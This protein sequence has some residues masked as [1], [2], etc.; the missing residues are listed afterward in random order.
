MKKNILILFISFLSVN[1]LSA[2]INLNSSKKFKPSLEDS[3]LREIDNDI[4]YTYYSPFSSEYRSNHK[5]PVFTLLKVDRGWDGKVT[6]IRFSG[7]A[8]SAFVK[9]YFNNSRSK[10]R[11]GIF[12][13]YAK[14]K[15]Y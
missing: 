10:N 4:Y 8:D 15:S 3:L 13:E 12:E 9:A 1:N 11:K 14:I 5:E 7:S 2:Q 6:A